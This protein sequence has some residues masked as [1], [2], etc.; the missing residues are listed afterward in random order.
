MKTVFT[1]SQIAQQQIWLLFMNADVDGSETG[2]MTAQ[3]QMHTLMT[4]VY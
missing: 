2:T 3:Q 1:I 4:N